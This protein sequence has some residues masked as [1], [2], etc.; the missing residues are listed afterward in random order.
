[1]PLRK[2]A[3]TRHKEINNLE[4]GIPMCVREEAR[5]MLPQ[6]EMPVTV[7]VQPDQD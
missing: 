5:Q 4:I 3:N 2:V 6:A 1:M 7:T